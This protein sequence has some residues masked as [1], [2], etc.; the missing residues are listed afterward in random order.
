[1][2]DF[3]SIAVEFHNH[4]LPGIDDGS[5]DMAESLAMLR[6]F[7]DLGF[8]K[9]IATPH[10][11]VE[12][13]VNPNKDILRLRDEVREAMNQ[14]G[15]NLELDAAAEYYYDEGFVEKV[16]QKD[17][18]TLGGNYV[19]MELPFPSRPGNLNENIYKLQMAGYKLILAH[20]E[21]YG[22]FHDKG[23]EAYETL[24]NRGVY[25]QIN[26]GSIIGKYG[27]LVKA[28]SERMIDLNM[29]EFVGS[30]MHTANQ[31]DMMQ[32]CLK[33]KSL[34]KLLSS[35]KLLNHTL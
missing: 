8:R 32:K 24:K 12:G 27:G 13:Y 7:A 20:P 31:K 29:V 5:R 2:T 16:A 11:M 23:F 4:I 19:L 30:D 10:S 34:S 15:I 9:V 17:L 35:G 6:Q 33:E 3:S 21:R 14:H 18:L 1:M 22:F 28:I 26:L 25:F